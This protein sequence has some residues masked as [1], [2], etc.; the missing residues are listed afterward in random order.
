LHYFCKGNI[1]YSTGV[2]DKRFS[3]NVVT[4]SNCHL[5]WGGYFLFMIMSIIFIASPAMPIMTRQKVNNSIYPTI[6]TPF[7]E[8][9]ETLLNRGLDRLPH[10][11]GTKSGVN[12]S[13]FIKK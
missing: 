6:C 5:D 12:V 3:L 7:P 1:I 4:E 10:G 2:T 8:G 13:T 11:H 9:K